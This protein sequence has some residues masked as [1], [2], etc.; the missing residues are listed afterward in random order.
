MTA[1]SDAIDRSSA[2]WHFLTRYPPR[3]LDRPE[4]IQL[5]RR[6][7]GETE[8]AFPGFTTRLRAAAL[9]AVT[10]DEL[11]LTRQ[12]LQCLATVGLLKDCNTLQRLDAEDT[13]VVRDVRTCLF[14][15][16]M[17]LRSQPVLKDG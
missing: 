8:E 13:L 3:Y 2:E 15:I 11:E 16:K 1:M 10:T 17:R 14:E 5:F 12:G 4:D 6:W 7:I 9:H